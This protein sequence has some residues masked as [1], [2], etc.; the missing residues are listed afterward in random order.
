MSR[1]ATCGSRVTAGQSAT[2]ET[3][4]PLVLRAG[5]CEEYKS[6]TGMKDTASPALP[7]QKF[8]FIYLETLKKLITSTVFFTGLT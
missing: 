1:Q 4:V 6:R 5:V 3:N 8:N 2:Q 7:S